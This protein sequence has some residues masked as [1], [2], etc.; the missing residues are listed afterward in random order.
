MPGFCVSLHLNL[1]QKGIQLASPHG[2]DLGEFAEQTKDDKMK[3]QRDT[4]GKK[5]LTRNVGNET[6][7]L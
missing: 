3:A 2:G 6:G 1:R 4:E 5:T 7:E